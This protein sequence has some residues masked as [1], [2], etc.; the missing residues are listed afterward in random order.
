M[1]IELIDDDIDMDDTI[2]DEE[3]SH[4]GDSEPSKDY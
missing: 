2:E 4:I 3:D 1:S